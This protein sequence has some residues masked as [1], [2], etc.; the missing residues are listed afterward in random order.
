VAGPD[1]LTLWSPVH[2]HGRDSSTVAEF[3]LREGNRVP[4]VL[5]YF[6]STDDL[7][8]PISGT[9]AVD[10][11]AQFWQQWA[12]M[13]NAELGSCVSQSCAPS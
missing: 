13:E 3:T 8:R 5:S 2:T 10:H 11:T 4:F 1:G 12:A 9:Y 7:P 6:T